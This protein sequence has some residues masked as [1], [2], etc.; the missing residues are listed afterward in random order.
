MSRKDKTEYLKKLKESLKY[1]RNL[2]DEHNANIKK[3]E[4]LNETIKKELPLMY[5]LQDS[6]DNIRLKIVQLN[7]ILNHLNKRNNELCCHWEK[8]NTNIKKAQEE[9]K[10][11]EEDMK[12]HNENRT[13]YINSINSLIK[14]CE[15]NENT[16]NII[17][18]SSDSH[19]L[20]MSIDELSND[21]SVFNNF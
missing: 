5:N 12:T 21:N 3:L 7:A 20:D 18:D 1:E 6:I 19:K 17:P 14:R 9:K 8:V 2:F 4:E 11:I 16:Y 13:K 15:R 10:Q